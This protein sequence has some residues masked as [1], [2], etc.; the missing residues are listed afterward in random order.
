MADR[1][2]RRDLRGAHLV[3]P[4]AGPY[5]RNPGR[6]YPDAPG[7]PCSIQ[8]QHHP[9]VLWPWVAPVGTRHAISEARTSLRRT[10]AGSYDGHGRMKRRDGA[11]GQ[12][13]GASSWLLLAAALAVFLVDAPRQARADTAEAEAAFR[14]GRRLAREGRFAEACPLFEASHRAAPALGA[15][16][17]LA[18]CHEEIGRTASAYAGYRAAQEMAR[19]RVDPREAVARDLA[20]RLAPRLTRLRIELAGIMTRGIVVRRG[21]T[22]ITADLGVAAAVDPGEHVLEASAP[23]YVTW[24][25]TINV[26]REGETTVVQVPALRPEP[27]SAVAPAPRPARRQPRSAPPPPRRNWRPAA[28]ETIGVIAGATFAAAVAVERASQSTYARAQREQG[29]AQ[30]DLEDRANQE[31]LI[32]QGLAATGVGLSVTA[33][34]LWLSRD[35]IPNSAVRDLALVPNVSAGGMAVVGR[36]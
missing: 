9:H 26:T 10:P 21:P 22:D 33:L 27:P 29:N 1:C 36:F 2:P 35:Q 14:E 28:A 8:R 5:A 12:V 15:L 19:V 7:V 20:D 24:L 23:G 31:L 3:A 16:L 11:G 4:V 25:E 6:A 34:Y 17:N 18:I 30:Q 13:R 32:A